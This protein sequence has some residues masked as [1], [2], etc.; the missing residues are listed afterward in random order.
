ME[1]PLSNKCSFL[2]RRTLVSKL[3]ITDNYC[4][5]HV[6]YHQNKIDLLA[7]YVDIITAVRCH[8]DICQC[9]K[10]RHFFYIGVDMGGVS[11]PLKSGCGCHGDGIVVCAHHLTKT[12][13]SSQG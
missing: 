7:V 11:H 2:N 10:K 5:I 6:V 12:N 13:H 4:T 8:G 1:S 3:A 9:K